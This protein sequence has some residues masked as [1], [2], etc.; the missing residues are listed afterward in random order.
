MASFFYEEE[1]AIQYAEQGLDYPVFKNVK[2]NPRVKTVTI[3]GWNDF[4]PLPNESL[5]PIL[6]L[7]DLEGKTWEASYW[8]ACMPGGPSIDAVT[9]DLNKR[10][11]DSL[12]RA[13]RAGRAQRMFI[14]DYD[15][16]RPT[17]SARVEYAS[18]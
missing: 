5:F 6:P 7:F 16:L 18:Q 12:D 11:N 2:D 10:Y 3:K 14:R 13:I 15:P 17:A 8:D 1:N 9:E 4:M